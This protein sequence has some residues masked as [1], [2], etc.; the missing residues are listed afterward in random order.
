M[1]NMRIPNTYLRFDFMSGVKERP[2]VMELGV[3]E[4]VVEDGNTP[5]TASDSILIGVLPVKSSPLLI[6]AVV[7]V[8]W[9]KGKKRTSSVHSRSVNTFKSTSADSNNIMFVKVVWK[10]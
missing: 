9:K 2:F 3:L 5:D 4:G 7:S 10:L 8:A 1:D 6:G